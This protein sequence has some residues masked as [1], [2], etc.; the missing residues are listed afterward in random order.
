MEYL[1][2]PTVDNYVIIPL[3]GAFLGYL[4]S[5]NSQKRNAVANRSVNTKEIIRE[6]IIVEKIPT[7]KKKDD[8]MLPIAVIGLFLIV[9]WQYIIHFEE[10]WKYLNLSILILVG[11]CSL[12]TTYT[13]VNRQ[14]FTP[15]WLLFTLLPAVMLFYCMYI[16]NRS[17]D[18]VPLEL[19]QKAN[20]MNPFEFAKGLTMFGRF[21]FIN[22]LV[23][24]VILLTLMLLSFSSI[25]Y[26]IAINNFDRKLKFRTFLLKISKYGSSDYVWILYIFLGIVSFIFLD[27]TLA[28][29][30]A[31]Q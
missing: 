7:E 21:F 22:Q 24:I 11:F 29:Y 30:F 20:N 5:M 19:I 3:I 13:I 8:Q 16:A 25:L 1:I 18:M 14:A 4:L 31:R 26:F 10:V 23:G 2:S 27:G 9:I 12:I 28:R 6:T 15:K 17:F